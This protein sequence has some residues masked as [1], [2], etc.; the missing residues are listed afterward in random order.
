MTKINGQTKKRF[1]I[2][3]VVALTAVVT[4]SVTAGGI[5]FLFSS[6]ISGDLMETVPSATDDQGRKIAYWRAPMNPTE[7][8]EKPGKSAMGMDLV[9]VYEDE[10][11]GGVAVTVDP[12]TQQNMGLRT[13]IVRQEPLE[14]TIRTYGHITADE[15]R[16]AQVNLKTG[17]WVEKLYVDYTGMYVEKGQPLFE[18]YSPELLAAQEEYLSAFKSIGSRMGSSGKDLLRSARRRLAYFDVSVGEIQDIQDLGKTQKTLV[19]RSPFTGYV[20]DR[21]VEEGSYVK[22]GTTIFRIA[23]LSNIWVEAHIYEYELP[24]I[25]EGLLAEMT[26]P[27]EPGRVFPGR[28]S[29][30]YPYLQPKTRD[31]VIRLEFANPDMKLKPDMYADVKIKTASEGTGMVIPVEAVIRSGE[32]NL[33]FV[34]RDN[35]KFTPR[36]VTLGPALDDGMVQ[37]FSGL[38]PS[39]VI[40]TSGQFLLD[41]ESKL[42]E[43]VQKML[44]AKRAEVKTGKPD[45]LETKESLDDMEPEEGFFDDMEE[46]E[47]FFKD[48]ED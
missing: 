6:G 47:D 2:L 22:K 20:I 5:Y 33:V 35:N 46:G 44:E 23:D 3:L 17:G 4:M 15:T 13:A 37:I 12:V 38:A 8:Y 7:I 26:L 30:V 32:R 16:T 40:V 11:V 27:Y 19:I 25:R 31:V 18:F 28:V 9:P 24:W 45:T 36:D 39:E 34:T 29:F 10:L 21:N 43:A 42:K 14:R 48:L 41:S 1:S